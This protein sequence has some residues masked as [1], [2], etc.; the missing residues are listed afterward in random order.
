MF[1]VSEACEGKGTLTVKDGQM[2]IHV[3][4]GSKNIRN[5]YLGS[6]K[7]AARSG[8]K[9]IEPTID[10]VTYKD[11]YQEEVFGFD[12]PV[13]VLDRE[14]D[15]ALIGKKGKWYDHKVKVSLAD[16]MPKISLENGSYSV[17][18][19]FEGGSGKAKILSP[20]V[21]TVSEEC[22]MAVV[23][24]NSPNYDYMVVEGEKILPSN[25]EGNSIFEIPVTTFDEPF[26][27]IGDTI[28][29]SKPHEVEYTLIFHSKTIKDTK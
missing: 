6:A 8:A 3:S 24:W 4:L 10:E 28:A 23:E 2:T 29:M 5:L 7:D 20:A 1:R 22:V 18:L 17:D 9:L 26:V 14:F 21:L 15:L 11:G 19:T 13:P 25:T 16:E 12:I 27:V